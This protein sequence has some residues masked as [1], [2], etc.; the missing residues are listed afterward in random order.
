M[1]QLF[2]MRRGGANMSVMGPMRGLVAVAIMETPEG[3]RRYITRMEELLAK[4][5]D[6]AAM[7]NRVIE[8]SAR[9]RPLLESDPELSRTN[10]SSVERLLERIPQ[11]YETMHQQLTSLRTPVAVGVLDKVDIQK[12]DSKRDSGNPDMKKTED[13]NLQ[14]TANGT[15]TCRGSWRAVYLLEPGRYQLEGDVIVEHAKR[16]TRPEGVATLRTSESDDGPTASLPQTRT[17]LV[18]EFT[19]STTRYVELIC[20]YRGNSGMAV[21]DGQSIALLRLNGT[22]PPA[23]V[24]DQKKIGKPPASSAPVSRQKF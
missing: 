6:V 10:E 24:D 15:V 14:I 9:L 3:R 19:V 23:V 16:G 13:G 18:H 5:F 2:S 8:T 22:A 1:D 12:W 7:T 17:N 21:F 20:E 11:R 4:Y